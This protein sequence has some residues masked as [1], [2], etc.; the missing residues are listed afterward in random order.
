MEEP[1]ETVGRER[2]KEID[3]ARMLC[4]LW[5]VGYWHLA[6][7]LPDSRCVYTPVGQCVTEIF[8]A[9]F[10]YISGFVHRRHKFSGRRDAQLFFVRKFERF[11]IL[12]FVA[13]MSLYIANQFIGAPMFCGPKQL[14]L[15]LCGLTTLFPPHAGMLWF[16][17]MIMLFYILT[18]FINHDKTG[19]RYVRI[20]CVQLFFFLWMAAV[21]EIDGMVFVY[22]T[23]YCLGLVSDDLPVD[24]MMRSPLAVIGSAIAV[25]ASIKYCVLLDYWSGG[26]PC[27]VVSPVLC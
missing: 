11:Y 10:F 15:T 21:G 9:C 13:T 2:I 24:N 22:F 25:L 4:A 1:T 23:V 7:Y 26:V 27:L 12:F 19:W 3:V 20:V 6:C 14:L 5:V 8:M 17:S 16:M 18:P